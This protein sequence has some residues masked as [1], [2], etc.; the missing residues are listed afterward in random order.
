MAATRHKKTLNATVGNSVRR[1]R[2]NRATW[3]DIAIRV[4]LG[5]AFAFVSGVYFTRAYAILQ[6]TYVAQTGLERTVDVYSILIMGLFAFFIAYL[7]AI[8]LPPVSKFAGIGPAVIAVAGAFLTWGLLLLHQRMDL[9]VGVKIAA[10]TL[11][12]VANIFALY[13]LHHLGRSFSIL[14]EGRELVT[15][16]P[17][18][19][20][21]HPLYIA[22][23]FAT[24][25][26]MI[27]FFSIA[28][29]ALVGAQFFLQFLRMYYE[30]KVLRSTFPEY[31]AYSRRTA[32][33]IPGI[34]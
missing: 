27:H 30:E 28:A 34:Y 3:I 32:R 25:G 33:L 24:I 26:A 29:I 5:A 6:Q 13:A 18:R 14:P 20:V 1:A 23:A 12:L 8:R 15:S 4:L 16:G 9:S 22:E 11:I 31:K 2:S 17:Y 7:Y 21:R 19:F 10:D